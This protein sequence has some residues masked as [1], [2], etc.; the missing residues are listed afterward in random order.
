[1]TTEFGRAIKYNKLT[2]RTCQ[3]L[4]HL[5]SLKDVTTYAGTPHFSHL[6]YSYGLTQSIH[7]EQ[8]YK[9]TQVVHA[10][11]NFFYVPSTAIW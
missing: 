10:D 5:V 7:L 11:S 8:I 6:W 2:M 1:M 9:Q 3:L 4:D